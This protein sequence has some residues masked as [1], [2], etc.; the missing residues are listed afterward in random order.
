MN[1]AA[2]WTFLNQAKIQAIR[3]DFSPE[4]LL[5]LWAECNDLMQQATGAEKCYG[6]YI[7]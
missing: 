6:Y 5:N 3:L 2:V 1:T 4:Q 7:G